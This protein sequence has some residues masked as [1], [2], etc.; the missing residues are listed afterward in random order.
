MS[1]HSVSI[2]DLLASQQ[3]TKYTDNVDADAELYRLCL[4]YKYIKIVLKFKK[5]NETI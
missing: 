3:N 5:L 2:D 1:K 4:Y